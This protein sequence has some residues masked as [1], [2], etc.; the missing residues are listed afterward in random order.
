MKEDTISP[1]SE[2]QTISTEST[3]SATQVVDIPEGAYCPAVVIICHRGTIDLM[4]RIWESRLANTE[5]IFLETDKEGMSLV[6]QLGMALAHERIT[7]TFVLAPANLIPCSEINLDDM[8]VPVV[9]VAK[10][11]EKSYSATMPM[12]F[13]VQKAQ[14]LLRE[15]L[16][17]DTY[18]DQEL[19]YLS[20]TFARKY[21]KNHRTRAIEVGMSFG[22]YIS[23]VTR[24][25]PCGNKVIEAMMRKKFLSANEVGFAAIA[26]EIEM[27]LK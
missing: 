8:M 21:A 7:P 2:T 19:A 14:D 24:G 26:S 5:M 11:G 9:Y 15:I 20:E 13:D 1:Q 18:T 12:T 6:E 22:N 17:E 25:T 16:T 27:T 4:K 3:E 10:N 23:P